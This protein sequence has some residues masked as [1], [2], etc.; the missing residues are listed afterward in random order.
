MKFKY[1]AQ[2]DSCGCAVACIS[3]VTGIPYE[4]VAKSFHTDF[5]HEGMTP[6]VMRNYRLRAWLHCG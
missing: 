2:K 1:I 6:E 3:M 4:K 5:K